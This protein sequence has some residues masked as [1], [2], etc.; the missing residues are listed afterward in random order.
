M[1]LNETQ[2]VVSA[3]A[4]K[5]LYETKNLQ[6]KEL[7]DKLWLHALACAHCAK[8]ISKE[9]SPG[10]AE[11]AFLKGLLDQWGFSADFV[12]IAKQHEW[13]K[14]APKTGKELLIVNLADNLAHKIG[15][16]FFD[17]DVSDLS[18]LSSTQLLEIAP[19]ALDEIGEEVKR[20][21]GEL[22]L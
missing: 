16:G 1:G 10:D 18:G 22:G 15:F 6:L 2:S 20:T 13:A 19:G 4:N 8:V 11:K 21:V 14:F 9:V 3:I 5:G 12:N 17:K 7:V